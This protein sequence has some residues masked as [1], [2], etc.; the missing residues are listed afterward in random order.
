MLHQKNLEAAIRLT[1]PNETVEELT[2]VDY[3]HK[4]LE[5]INAIGKSCAA[6]ELARNQDWK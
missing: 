3:I 6:L 1:C 5:V 2:N 4:H